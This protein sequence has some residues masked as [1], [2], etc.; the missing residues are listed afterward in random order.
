[1]VCCLEIET[2]KGVFIRI[3]EPI[4]W[5]LHCWLSLTLWLDVLTLI[6]KM[7][8]LVNIFFSYINIRAIEEI[9]AL[10]NCLAKSHCQENSR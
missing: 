6:L 8:L 9:L 4:T 10:D 5:P 3:H 1:M 2:S 7:S